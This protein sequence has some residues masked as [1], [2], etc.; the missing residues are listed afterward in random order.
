VCALD[1]DEDAH[2]I[3]VDDSNGDNVS[4]DLNRLPLQNSGKVMWLNPVV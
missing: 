1:D 2:P 3:L 4:A